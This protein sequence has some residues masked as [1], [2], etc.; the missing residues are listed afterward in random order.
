MS[1]GITCG[2]VTELQLAISTTIN[3][4]A[5]AQAQPDVL[6]QTINREKQLIQYAGVRFWKDTNETK[7]D[8]QAVDTGVL[9]VGHIVGGA[10]RVF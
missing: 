6:D 10:M 8:Q 5:N 3:L 9:Y 2:L 7:V 4:C 1:H